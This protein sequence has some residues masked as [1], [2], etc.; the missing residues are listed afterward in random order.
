MSYVSIAV[1]QRPAY[2][3]IRT[4]HFH[5]KEVDI[6]QSMAQEPLTLATFLRKAYKLRDELLEEQPIETY[7]VAHKSKLKLTIRKGPKIA[8]ICNVAKDGL[9]VKIPKSI[10]I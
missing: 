10:L 9:K 5:N 3:K 2:S 1:S 7:H 6:S 4:E 8:R